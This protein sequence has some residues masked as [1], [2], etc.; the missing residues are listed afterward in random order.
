M[1][2]RCPRCKAVYSVEGLKIDFK[3]KKPAK[4]TECQSLFYVE[5]P[6][7]HTKTDEDPG[8]TPFLQSF[9]EKRNGSDRRHNRDRRKIIDTQTLPFPLPSK[10]VILLFNEENLPIGYM[11][12]GQRSGTDRRAGKER[13]SRSA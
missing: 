12:H 4:C 13:R 6:R 9:F 3:S 7:R 2:I 8:R 1:R 11:S 5:M 10:D